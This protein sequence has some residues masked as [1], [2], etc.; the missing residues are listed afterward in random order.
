M[1]RYTSAYSSLLLRLKEVEV[2]RRSAAAKERDDPIKLR[3]D[4]NAF[5]RAGIVL[6]CAH[7]EAYVKELGE[8]ALTNIHA[9]AV[10]RTMLAS[11]FFYHLSKDLLDEVRD[12]SDPMK[13]AAKVF[14]FLQQDATYWGRVGPFPIPLPVDRFNK[15]FANP[16]FK[17]VRAY[18]NRF[19]YADYKVELARKLKADYLVTV[20]M[21]DHLVDTRNKIAHGDPSV[22]KTPQDVKEMIRIIRVYC[23]ATDTIFASWCKQELCTIR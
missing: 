15:G 17:K 13:I 3:H 12:T 7:L 23:K 5:C 19:G 10:P 18:L 14:D 20:N 2:L 11:Q 8:V 9:R 4:I 21:V 22:T 16:A 1:P 6:L